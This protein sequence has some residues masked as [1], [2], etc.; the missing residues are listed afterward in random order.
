MKSFRIRTASVLLAAAICTPAIAADRTIGEKFDD[1]WIDGSIETAM[2]FN[3]H[4]NAFSI[5]SDVKNGEVKLTGVVASDIDRSL[6]GEIAKGVD[7]VKSVDNEITVGNEQD[8]IDKLSAKASERTSNLRQWA[9]DAT[10]TAEIKTRLLANTS[11]QG[12]KINVDTKADVV[13]LTGKV[14]STEEAALA[15]QIASNV[16]DVSEVNNRL[17]VAS[18]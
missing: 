12:L 1:A 15:E 3:S 13:T 11:T 2:L 6:A 5:R 8:G 17:V 14:A 18:R 16:E 7:G 10:T 4:L 9:T